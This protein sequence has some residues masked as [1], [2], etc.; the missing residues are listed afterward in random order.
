MTKSSFEKVREVKQRFEAE[1]LNL[2][3]VIGVGIGLRQKGGDYTDEVALIVMVKKKM[4]MNEVTPEN[5]IP[6]VL[7]GVT[8]DV[9]EVGEIRARI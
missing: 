5:L 8:V 1:L 3:N 7:D 6:V 4:N 9:Q 2:E